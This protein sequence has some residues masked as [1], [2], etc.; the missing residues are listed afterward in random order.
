VDGT[1]DLTDATITASG[2]ITTTHIADTVRE[3]N[4]PLMGFL[5]AGVPLVDSGTLAPGLNEDDNVMGI[6]WA[7]GEVTPVAIN[8]RVPADYASGGSFRVIATESDSSTANQI[9]F[10]VYTAATGAIYNATVTDQTPAAL[11]LSTNTPS[12]VT[13]TVATDFSA[14]AAGHLVALEIWRDDTADGT[15]TLEVKNVSF[16]YTASS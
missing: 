9:D 14:L 6:I 15:G 1:I 12:T 2:L 7:D 4:L 16:Y 13:L 3:L 11:T 10:Q 8:F 5:A